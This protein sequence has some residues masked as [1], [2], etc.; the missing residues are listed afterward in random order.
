MDTYYIIGICLIGMCLPISRMILNMIKRSD[1]YSEKFKHK[2]GIF[3]NIF[4]ILCF[5][6]VI[7]LFILMRQ[8]FNEAYP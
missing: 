4:D 1:K 3:K 6:A 7:I 8:S 5:L 2:A